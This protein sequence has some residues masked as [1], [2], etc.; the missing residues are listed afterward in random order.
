MFSVFEKVAQM[1]PKHSDIVLLE[2]YAA[3]QNRLV[4]LSEHKVMHD[5]LS[6]SNIN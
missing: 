2:N 1:D 6:M 3:F 5:M 4:W